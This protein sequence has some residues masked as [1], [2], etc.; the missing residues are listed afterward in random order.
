MPEVSETSLPGVGL[1]YDFV[2][3]QGA[4]VGVLVH[5]TGR[6][7]L[8]VYSADDP[9]S[10]AARLTLEPEDA[11]TLAEL[12][13]ASRIAEHL[14]AVQQDIE[15]LSIDWIKIEPGSEWARQ[16]LSEVGVHTHTGV[17]IVALLSGDNVIAAPGADDRLDPGATAVAVGTPEGLELLALKVRR[18]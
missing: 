15:G 1:R 14:A 17:S 2:T 5:R 6:R 3:L 10:L 11:Q 18:G 9:D 16:T 13:G 8:L 7:E 4:R 12:F